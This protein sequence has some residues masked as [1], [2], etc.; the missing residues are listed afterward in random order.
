MLESWQIFATGI[1]LG[2]SIAAPPGPVNAAAAYQVTRSWF[3]GWSTLLG[4]TTADVVFFLLTYYGVTALVASGE[5]RDAL[6]AVGGLFMSY[7]S[8]AT[9]RNAR[10]E[11]REEKRNGRPYVLG[12]TI[13]L[14]NPFQLA[15]WVA[16]GIGMVSTF[17]LSIVLGFFGGILA[18]TLVY[19][20]LLRAGLS[21]YR[22]VYPYI[23]YA[24]GVV[25]LAFGVWFF[26][27]AISSFL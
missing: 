7:L 14:S 16:V 17:G 8:Y 21:R 18:W 10:R 25:L 5:V 20:S 19:S 3:A 12:L 6:F 1:F 23:A 24:S 26:I 15:W 11:P 4:A 2:I 27:T 13:G 9:L 22:E